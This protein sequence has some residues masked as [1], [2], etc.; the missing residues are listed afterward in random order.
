MTNGQ[1]VEGKLD[2]QGVEPLLHSWVLISLRNEE[3]EIFSMGTIGF[4]FSK[5]TFH[6]S[7]T[8]KMWHKSLQ[9]LS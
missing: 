7:K 1:I 9:L 6:M 2:N 8:L 5:L 4:S 3:M